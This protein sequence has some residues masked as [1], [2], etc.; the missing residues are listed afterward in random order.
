[1]ADDLHGAVLVDLAAELS[2]RVRL[3]LRDG[4]ASRRRRH[5]ELAG[6]L[7]YRVLRQ[8]SECI[9]GGV[10]VAGATER[11]LRVL[12]DEPLRAVE[13]GRSRRALLCWNICGCLHFLIVVD[14]CDEELLVFSLH[15]WK[16]VV[17]V[18]LVRSSLAIEFLI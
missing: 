2:R 1:M 11:T 9:D 5:T 6:H 15:L 16:V 17:C 14:L 10:L 12:L 18:L 3:D 7:L 4:P 8:T 13:L